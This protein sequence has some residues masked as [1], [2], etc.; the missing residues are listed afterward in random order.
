MVVIG[1]VNAVFRYLGRFTGVDLSSN[2]YLESQWYLFSIVFLLAASYTLRQGAHVR[3]DVL[4]GRLSKKGQAWL[5]LAGG[6]LFLIPFSVLMIWASWS[7][8]LNSWD[9]LE[10]SPDPGGLPRYPLKTIIPI[11]FVLL[12]LQGFS[13]IIKSAATIRGERDVG[14]STFD[15]GRDDSESRSPDPESP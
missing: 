1:S 13:E 11:T 15:V 2:A 6:V 14:R 5:N 3:V 10:I 12:I 8:V 4:Y 9:V 7:W